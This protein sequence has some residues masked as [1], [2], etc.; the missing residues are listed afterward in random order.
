MIKNVKAELKF[1]KCIENKLNM[2]KI[3]LCGFEL[4]TGTNH[5]CNHSGK[6]L[7]S[8]TKNMHSAKLMKTFFLAVVCVSNR[9][10]K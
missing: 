8:V 2:S 7:K 9:I 5:H 10:N 3:W 1:T 6:F 4:A